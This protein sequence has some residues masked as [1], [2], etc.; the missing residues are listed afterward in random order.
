M[1]E[2][3][4]IER[5]WVA[6]AMG[7]VTGLFVGVAIGAGIASIAHWHLYLGSHDKDGME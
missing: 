1:L 6:Y 4:D 7:A 2:L 3:P 5:F